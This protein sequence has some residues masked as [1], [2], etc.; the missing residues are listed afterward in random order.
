MWSKIA[1]WPTAALVLA[2]AS[3][4]VYAQ[5]PQKCGNELDKMA[6]Y[7]PTII[8]DADAFYNSMATYLSEMGPFETENGI[9]IIPV[10]VHVLHIGGSENISKTQI[11]SQITA[12]NKDFNAM[13]S[14][15][16]V[17]ANGT[18]LGH[19]VFDSLT[20]NA[21]IE[22]R[23]ATLDP[24]GNCTDGIVRVYTLK[25]EDALTSNETEFK[26]ASYWDRSKYLNMWV[27]RNIESTGGNTV[28]GFAQ[29]PF[30]NGNTFP[31]TS[32]DGVTIIHNAF[33]TTG[34][35]AG[36]TGATTT[37]EVGHWLGLRHIWGDADCGND[38]VDDTPIH[39]EPNYCN[40]G[41]PFPIPKVADCYALTQTSSL[42]D[43]L[44]RDSIG[45]MWMN[46][47][48][49]TSDEYLWMFSKGQVDVFNFTFLTYAF[50]G[51]I[52]KEENAVATGT[53]DNAQACTPAPVADLWSRE[54]TNKFINF[55][56]ICE[57]DNLKFENGT[58][59][60]TAASTAWTFEGGTPATSAAL[61]P[62]VVYNT[63][64]TYDVSLTSTNGSGT[65]TA[66]RPD[67][68]LVSSNAAEDVNYVYFDPFEGNS[69]YEA[70]KWINANEYGQGN[71]WESY[72]GTGYQSAKCV[73]MRNEGNIKLE[74]DMLITPSYDLSQFTGDQLSFKFAYA[75]RTNNPFVDQNDQLRLYSSTDC[76]STW[77]TRTMKVG[78][79][80]V[81]VL[82]GPKLIT[83]G[84][85]PNGFVPAASTDW[86]T[87][88]SDLGNIGSATNVRFMFEFTSG[89]SFGNN[90]Y[91]DNFNIG[92]A[93]SVG[94]EDEDQ[95]QQF[96]VYPNPVVGTST[97]R[98]ESTV[99]GQTDIQVLDLTGRVVFNVYSG[100]L[101]AGTYNF[102]ISKSQFGASGVYMVKCTSQGKSSF[103]KIVVN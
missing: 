35:A 23:L 41:C 7:D 34:S 103:K 62:T 98:F 6:Q 37:H 95:A 86:N 24:E 89:G 3:G 70:G 46:F 88:L 84:L 51:N 101:G 65:S 21:E 45:E 19:H 36:G 60:G 61:E 63:P 71:A 82:S 17:L 12:L 67:F 83:A 28:L 77:Q 66:S 73:R 15:L 97:I 9:R 33:G 2:L 40:L 74:R 93:N 47:M 25:A 55:K 81:S 52:I 92:S 13:N 1:K 54:G 96:D 20:G 90:L 56:M 16:S 22:F 42:Q 91:I 85:A 27:V 8:Q 11:Q 80:T 100:D 38:M 76:G 44:T 53:D 29:F 75:S 64:G 5:T 30:Q 26:K 49:Y 31:L 48:D 4:G 58:Y 78:N 69:L 32:T 94:V 18:T 14:G 72:S 59:G 87:V 99:S 43:T 79:S 10:V 102:E 39:R 50:R 68:V 57:G